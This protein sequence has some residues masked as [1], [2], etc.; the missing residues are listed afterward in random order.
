MEKQ[1]ISEGNKLIAEFMGLTQA[2]G[3]DGVFHK[4]VWVDSELDHYE[5]LEY[6]SSYNWLMPVVEKICNH[7][8][9]D[10]QGPIDRAFPRTFGAKDDQGQ[11]MVRFNRM[12]LYFGD[13]LIEAAYK[14]VVDFIKALE[15]E[16]QL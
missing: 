7:E 3:E 14:A 11:F 15:A 4:G 9:N 5:S 1:E 10:F 8:F 12:S 2:D 13:T 6:D 16:K